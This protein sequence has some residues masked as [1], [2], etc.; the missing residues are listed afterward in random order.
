[1]GV[2]QSITSQGVRIHEKLQ[3]NYNSSFLLAVSSW[4]PL[5]TL[6]GWNKCIWIN[7][8]SNDVIEAA[9]KETTLYISC[10]HTAGISQDYHGRYT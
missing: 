5:L 4:I 2:A 9:D 8:T 6:R 1:M 7:Y 10:D 3:Y